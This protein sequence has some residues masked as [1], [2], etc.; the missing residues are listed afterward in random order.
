MLDPASQWLLEKAPI[1]LGF[2]FV[3]FF[4][5]QTGKMTRE[6]QVTEGSNKSSFSVESFDANLDKSTCH[7]DLSPWALSIAN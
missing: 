5:W 3:F 7:L 1:P 2:G 6:G 4:F